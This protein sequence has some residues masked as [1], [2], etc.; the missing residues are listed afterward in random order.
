MRFN[1]LYL[2][3]IFSFSLPIIALEDTAVENP[4]DVE[5]PDISKDTE[6]SDE[7]NKWPER[8]EP[9]GFEVGLYPNDSNG[10]DFICDGNL[11]WGK[12][13]S[14]GILG[15]YST[16]TSTYEV[17][18]VE[19]TANQ[20]DIVLS[21]DLLKYIFP[22]AIKDDFSLSVEPGTNIEYSNNYLETYGYR[23]NSDDSITFYR[24]ELTTHQ[25]LFSLFTESTILLGN[26]V[27]LNLRAEYYPLIYIHEDGEKYYSSLDTPATFIT[28]NLAMGFRGSLGISF[29]LDSISNKP[30]GRLNLQ[31][32]F[33]QQFGNYTSENVI[34]LDNWKTTIVDTE[35]LIRR[36]IE[37]GGSYDLTPLRRWMPV[38][39]SVSVI[40]ALELEAFGSS[41][42]ESSRIKIGFSTK[43]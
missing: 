15:S 4:N 35:N 28:Q 7:E 38:V 27:D 41:S 17:D 16:N 25:G 9:A 32:S 1:F 23:T 10:I 11:L 14:S 29:D 21:I 37:F 3:L 22:L 36:E 42:S 18:T 20:R 6:E 43:I 26:L 8:L 19:G 2:L 24:N 33:F 5:S 30:I 34:A 31:A 39:P 40:Y 12:S 13:I